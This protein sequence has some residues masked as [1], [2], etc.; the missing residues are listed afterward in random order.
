MFYIQYPFH[1]RTAAPRYC[2]E[3]TSSK[4]ISLVM[5]SEFNFQLFDLI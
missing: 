5:A 2:F 1:Y 3:C 4:E